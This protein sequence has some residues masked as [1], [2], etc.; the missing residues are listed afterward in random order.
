M[1]FKGKRGQQLAR[2]IGKRSKTFVPG[3]PLPGAAARAGAA[4]AAGAAAPAESDGPPKK[5]VE[6]IKVG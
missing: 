3:A 5:D 2:D 4:S 6:A 1:M